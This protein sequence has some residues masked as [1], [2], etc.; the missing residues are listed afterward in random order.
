MPRLEASRRE[1]R[2]LVTL[3]FAGWALWSWL[4]GGHSV[5]FVW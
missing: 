3:A 2:A 5:F 1:Q 4:H